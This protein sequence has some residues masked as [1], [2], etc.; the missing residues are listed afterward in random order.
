MSHGLSDMWM[1]Q[2][3]K[4]MSLA[5]R[6]RD[7]VTMAATFDLVFLAVLCWF[8]VTACLFDQPWVENLFLE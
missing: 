6:S 8:N 5:L 3:M 1:Q 7:E 4:Q 2:Q